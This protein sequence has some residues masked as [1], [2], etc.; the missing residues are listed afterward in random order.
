MRLDPRFTTRQFWADN[1]PYQTPTFPATKVLAGQVLNLIN[2][3]TGLAPQSFVLEVGAGN[4]AFSS[5][6]ASRFR[7]VAL[8]LSHGLL[9]E[10]PASQRVEGDVFC[11][12]F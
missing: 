9:S 3:G 11:L 2:E 8:D 1:D 6:F 5:A 12:P 7:F 10:N 4:G